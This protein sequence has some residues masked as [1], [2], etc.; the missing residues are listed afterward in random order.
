MRVDATAILGLIHQEKSDTPACRWFLIGVKGID[1]RLQAEFETEIFVNDEG[2]V[3]IS[4]EGHVCPSC[5]VAEDAIVV[6]GTTSR[7]R[8]IANELMRLA[9]E[10]ERG[11]Q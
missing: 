11:R 8:T 7:L 2:S 9:A 5:G 4:Q 3:T 10:L 1:M 6:F